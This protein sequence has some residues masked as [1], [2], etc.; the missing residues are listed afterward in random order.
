M[1]RM[2]KYAVVLMAT[3]AIG[4]FWANSAWVQSD[5][6][7]RPRDAA[8]APAHPNAPP[9]DVGLDDPPPGPPDGGPADRP[10]RPERRRGGDV[11]PAP[12]RGWVATHINLGQMT[13]V[14]VLA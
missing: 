7:D 5:G 12:G 8:A 13:V 10:E 4:L 14:A 11:R 2:K 6:G 9:D 1:T 3:V